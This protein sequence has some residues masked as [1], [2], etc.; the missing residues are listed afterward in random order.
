MSDNQSSNTQDSASR[1]NYY[2]IA[3]LEDFNE[4]LKSMED[5]LYTAAKAMSL[6][7]SLREAKDAIE[8]DETHGVV[9]PD[10]VKDKWKEAGDKLNLLEERL[11]NPND[12]GVKRHRQHFASQR[13]G[14]S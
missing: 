2:S 1:S 12:P 6:H 13:R 3:T 5:S 7:M 9:V 8:A 4:S 11:M 14:S 10:G